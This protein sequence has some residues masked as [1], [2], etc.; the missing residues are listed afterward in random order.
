MKIPNPFYELAQSILHTADYCWSPEPLSFARTAYTTRYLRWQLNARFGP[1]V[2]LEGPQKLTAILLSWKR[3]RNM[4]PIVRSLLR[5]DFIDRIIVSN[6]NPEYRIHDELRL[7]DERLQ[8]IDQPQPRAP[9]I[10]FE[11]ARQQPGEYFIS[12]DDDIFLYPEQV[13]QLFQA[14]L[15]RP[16]CAHSHQGERY[17]GPDKSPVAFEPDQPPGW[18]MCLRRFEGHVDVINCVYAF[19]RE[20]VAEMYRLAE[21]LHLDVG[22]LANGEDLLLSFSGEERPMIHDIGLVADCLTTHRL[23]VATWRTREDFFLERAELFLKVRAI[24]KLA[25]PE[26]PSRRAFAPQV[27]LA[28]GLK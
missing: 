1:R 15:S 5:C 3:V 16:G 11:L 4:Q 6:N 10:R 7:R 9:G 18:E 14:L 27:R 19:T 26:Q 25:Q 2:A 28:G 13:K 21:Q 8:L 12:I 22:A 23:G 20:H 24:K 17:V